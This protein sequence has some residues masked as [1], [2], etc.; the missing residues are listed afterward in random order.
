MLVTDQYNSTP[1]KFN[2]SVDDLIMA[3][4]NYYEGGELERLKTQVDYLQGIVARILETSGKSD[5]DIITLL[6]LDYRYTV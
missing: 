6:G 2:L 3:N 1:I 5:S 4:L